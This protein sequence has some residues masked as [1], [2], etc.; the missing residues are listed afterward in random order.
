MYKLINAAE[1]GFPELDRPLIIYGESNGK[2]YC[3]YRFRRDD[4]AGAMHTLH[5]L[6]NPKLKEAESDAA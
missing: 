5:Q 6:N 4:I 2:S 1:V 3:L